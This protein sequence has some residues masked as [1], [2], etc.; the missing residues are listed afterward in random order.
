MCIV[1]LSTLSS[2][3]TEINI[4]VAIVQMVGWM[5]NGKSSKIVTLSDGGRQQTINHLLLYYVLPRSTN[6]DDM[7]EITPLLTE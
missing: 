7:S 6:D 3:E 1:S 4:Q 5:S 2:Q